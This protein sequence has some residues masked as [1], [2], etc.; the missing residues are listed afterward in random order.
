MV[1][2]KNPIVFTAYKPTAVAVKKAKTIL[3]DLLL[4]AK[5]TKTCAACGLHDFVYDSVREYYVCAAKTCAA[6]DVVYDPLH[7]CK[8]NYV[9]IELLLSMIIDMQQFEQIQA[10]VKLSKPVAK[11]WISQFIEQIN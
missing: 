10:T 2:K 11:K 1:K 3:Q 5:K 4:N 7:G 9:K 8:L 6:P